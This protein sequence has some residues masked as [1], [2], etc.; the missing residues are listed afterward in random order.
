MTFLPAAANSGVRFRRVDLE[1]KP[2]IE[3]RI[4]NVTDTTRSTTLSKGNVK[5]HTV[6]HVLATFAGFGIDNAIIELDAN[7]PPIGDG[8]ARPYSRMVQTAGVVL[9]GERRNPFRIPHPV[10]IQLAETN[11]SVF[12][13][14]SLRISCTS[15]DKQG[16][17]TQ[18]YSTEISPE[19]WSKE[20]ASARTFCFYEE[21]EFLIKNGLIRGG[22]LENAVVIRDDAVLTTEPLR[23]PEEFVRHKI[24][25]LVGDLALLGR[26]LYGHVVAIKPSHASNCELTRQL[27][28]LMRKPM[29]A[30]QAFAPPLPPEAR[31]APRPE[32]PA[33]KNPVADPTLLDTSELMKILPHRYPFLMVDRV[34]KIE[35]NTIRGVKNVS[36]N[37]PFF[38]G[39]FPNHP[40]MP[41]V[42]QL[43]AIAQVA[44]ILMLKQAENWGKIAYFMSA[45]SV[46]WR[47]PVRPGDRLVIDVE[48]T[49][50][51]G[52]IGKAKGVCSVDGET[53]S[54]AEVAFMLIE[55]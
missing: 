31:E 4:E 42:L 25:D 13:H 40:V 16:R 24:L 23:F 37:E 54:E 11:I 46:K 38:Q 19:N 47:K 34:I 26:P 55:G 35:G 22:S 51:R 29:M 17:F 8:S 44:G 6:E 10:E 41:G 36:I 32:T 21:I 1:G 3:A 20:L 53:V 18:F 33:V 49:K 39:H 30:V 2:E 28:A 5:V 48:L 15:L 45:E 9:Q 7:E 12:P 14:D 27:S 43:E 50:S 52:K